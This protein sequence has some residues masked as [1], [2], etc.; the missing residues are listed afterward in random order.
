MANQAFQDWRMLLKEAEREPTTS[1]KLVKEEP[2][3]LGWVD[4]SREGVGVGWILGKDA[5]RPTIW[6]LEWPKKLRYRLIT[7]TNPGVD[8]DINDLQM[9]R[10][11]QAWL[12]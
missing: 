8:L 6:R 12:V 2:E 7:P 4:A 1:N 11:F 5:L 10:K 3:F 9:S